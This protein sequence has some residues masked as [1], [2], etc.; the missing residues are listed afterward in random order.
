MHYRGRADRLWLHSREAG[1]LQSLLRRL[2]AV[3]VPR[4]WLLLRFVASFFC[5]FWFFGQ[6]VNF[7]PLFDIG[8]PLNELV[9]HKKDLNKFLLCNTV[10]DMANVLSTEKQTAIIAALAEVP[11]S[12]PSSALR[13]FTAITIMRLGAKVGARMHRSARSENAES[14]VR[15][16]ILQ[17]RGTL[18]RKKARSGV[19]SYRGRSKGQDRACT[20]CRR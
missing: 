6:L 11:A 18:A 8:A 12:A 3:A 15:A 2:A 19:Q 14:A 16:V 4:L 20:F 5:P 17:E 7:G 1:R 13:A 10:S 9:Y